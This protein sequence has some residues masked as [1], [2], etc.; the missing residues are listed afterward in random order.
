MDD[1]IIIIKRGIF[2]ILLFFVSIAS[3]K[4]LPNLDQA[5]LYQQRFAEGMFLLEKEPALA[6]KIFEELYKDTKSTRVQLEWAR[7]LY[8]AKEYD[9][10]KAV[11]KDVLKEELPLPVRDKVEGF[12]S[13]IDTHIQPFSINFGLVRDSNPRASPEE[14]QINI[15]GRDTFNYT[16]DLKAQ[17]QFGALLGLSYVSTQKRNNLA[18]VFA[19]LDNY[20]YE[21]SDYDTTIARL[22]VVRREA[23][24]KNIDLGFSL[25]NNRSHY[26]TQYNAPSIMLGYNIDLYNALLISFNIKKMKY[27]YNST[28]YRNNSIEDS[29]R[30]AFD[31]DIN[32]YFKVF[33]DSTYELNKNSEN[34]KDLSFNGKMSGLGFKW[35][36]KKG[37]I[38]VT[39]RS[40][41]SW[42]NYIGKVPFF[43]MQRRDIRQSE[44]I[45]LTK[46][47]FY[48][49]GFR[50]YL[51]FFRET[52]SS[53]IPI[54]RYKKTLF[55]L[56]VNKVF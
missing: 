15:L 24:L 34:I 49:Y 10:A 18:N 42:R 40:S 6:A 38:E 33:L 37:G 45:S 53:T 4:A 19:K 28:L 30:V 32:P 27:I 21:N 54:A 44:S 25:L 1:F 50:P 39:G 29:F 3:L 9:A 26:K 43:D 22:T 13:T 47:D 20:H 7:S 16:P 36:S 8:A 17:P 14:Q 12:L 52:N 41:R 31:L 51:E 55:S 11:F 2:A 35:A 56:M 5:K 23:R 46:R 48:F